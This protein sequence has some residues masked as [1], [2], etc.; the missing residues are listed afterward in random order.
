MA[1]TPAKPASGSTQ[2]PAQGRDSSR[3]SIRETF[4]SIIIA[5]AMAFVF[6]A[7]VIEA[8]VIPTGSMAPT[9]LGQHVEVVSDQ[10]GARWQV[11][12]W[13][14]GTRAESRYTVHDPMTASNPPALIESGVAAAR[15][16]AYQIDT[17]V[18][19]LR[20]GDR[21]LVLKYLPIIFEPERFDVVVFKNPTDPTVN[22]IKRL[23]GLPGEQWAVVDGDVFTR[24]LPEGDA[25]PSEADLDQPGGTWAMDG[26]AIA[27]KPEEAQRA[28]WMPVH[29]TARAP[30]DPIRDG[31]NWYS[32]PWKAV[33]TSGQAFNGWENLDGTTPEHTL[34]GLTRLEWDTQA[35]PIVDYYPYNERY[36]RS[37]ERLTPYQPATFGVGDV[38]VRMG[39]EPVG[40]SLER[41]A[42]RIDTRS[43]AFR[44]IISGGTARIETRPI[45]TDDTDRWTTMAE[46][47]ID[48]PPAGEVTDVEFWHADQA[49]WLFVGGKKVAHATY[50]WGPIERLE[51]ATG[52]PLDA[53][54]PIVPPPNTYRSAKPA[55]AL[56]GPVKLHRLALDR[57]LY[58]QS[59]RGDSQLPVRG[60]HPSL[61]LAILDQ[62]Q[63]F[64]CGDNSASSQDS[65]LLGEP[66]P[67]VSPLGAPA[68]IVPSEL[69]LGRA[70]FVYFPAVERRGAVP[71]P[72]FGRLRFIW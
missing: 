18:E 52:Q 54:A 31:Y 51:L 32:P 12:P 56:V 67:W 34:P 37:G 59:T 49:L 60:S 35:W 71:I 4:S 3:F 66:S 62:G 17:E 47:G 7:F 42:V 45:E 19:R 61:D 14:D 28:V 58:Y 10:T 48:Q 11:G 16:P 36:R 9:L 2:S 41:L 22:Y 68:G 70:F 55:I 63:F 30:V 23:T 15:S 25:N 69:M 57:D 53:R 8:F 1:D 65:R 39:V 13:T 27:R 29:D 26:W 21:I 20:A 44:A 43:H 6:R 72:G 40:Q 50:D 5:F 38:R 46:A 24:P 64:V 33:S